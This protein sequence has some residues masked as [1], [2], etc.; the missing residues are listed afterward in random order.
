VLLLLLLWMIESSPHGM[1]WFVWGCCHTMQ[2]I[3]AG[4]SQGSE[5]ADAAIH[6]CSIRVLQCVATRNYSPTAMFFSK[7]ELLGHLKVQLHNT[8]ASGAHSQPDC[9]AAGMTLLQDCS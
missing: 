6:G 1:S 3:C 7:H 2:C 8:V 4:L 5:A 9:M